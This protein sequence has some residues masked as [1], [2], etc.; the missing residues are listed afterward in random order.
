MFTHRL[1]EEAQPLGLNTIEVDP[2]MTVD[3]LAGRV[4]EA[5]GL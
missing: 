1:C 4:A 3:E 2:T 5:L